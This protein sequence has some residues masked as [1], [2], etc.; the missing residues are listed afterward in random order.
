MSVGQGLS[1]GELSE[2]TGIK[3]VTLR[4]WERRHGLLRPRRSDGGHRLYR[5]EDVQ[6]VMA[7][8][9]WLEQGVSIGRVQPLLARSADAGAGPDLSS[10][11]DA[12]MAFNSRHLEQLFN[13]QSR[14]TPLPNLYR[15]W[16]EPVRRELLALGAPA[17]VALA[18]WDR[19]LTQKLAARILKEGRRLAQRPRVLVQALPGADSHPAAAV[20][21]LLAMERGWTSIMLGQSLTGSSLRQSRLADSLEARVLVLAPGSRL[22]DLRQACR[23][24][25]RLALKHLLLNVSARPVAQVSGTVSWHCHSESPLAVIDSLAPEALS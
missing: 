11:V 10:V 23:G 13:E 16:L 2:A 22:A 25:E 5:P 7:I 14:S 6:R 24:A 4:A 8:R 20:C 1:I 3:T 18:F 9:G 12:C 17:A 15:D 19:F 21:Q